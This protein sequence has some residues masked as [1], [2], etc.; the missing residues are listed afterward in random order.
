MR[1]RTLSPRILI[2][3]LGLS[4]G[5]LAMPPAVAACSCAWASMEDARTQPEAVVFTGIT[6]P[7]DARGYPVTVTRWF[8]GGGLFELRAWLHPGGFSL[9][10]DGAD[11]SIPPLPVGTAYIFIAHQHEGMYSVGLCSPHATLASAE[12]QAMLTDADRVFGGGDAPATSPPAAPSE[13]PSASPT[14]APQAPA[15]ASAMQPLLAVVLGVLGVGV[16]VGMIGVLRR[17][18]REDD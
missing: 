5:T 7:R 14:T 3:V 11:C 8:K 18:R 2:L 16:L 13:G 9:V 1:R 4:L 6:E 10:G 17:S 15:P 12:G